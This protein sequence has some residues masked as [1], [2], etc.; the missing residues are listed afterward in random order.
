MNTNGYSL[1]AFHL[2]GL[3]GP[4]S[5]RFSKEDIELN[6]RALRTGSGQ[7]GP[8]YGSEP[9]AAQFSRS[10]RPKRGKNVRA[11]FGPFHLNWP[12]PGLF[13]H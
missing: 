6:G 2:S 7:N 9:G 12:E 8:A 13:D 1:V 3:T 11:R 4:T 5:C 10:G